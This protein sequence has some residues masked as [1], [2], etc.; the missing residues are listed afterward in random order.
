MK[1][2]TLLLLP[3]LFATLL[4]AEE[5]KNS[6]PIFIS[7]KFGTTVIRPK[8]TSA[9]TLKSRNVVKQQMDFSCGS[10]AVGTIFAFYLDDPIPEEMIIKGLFHFGNKENIVKNRGFSLLDIKKLAT[11]LGYK[12]AGYKTDI[13]GLLSLEQPAIVTITIGNYKHFVVFRG[14]EGNRVYLADPALGNMTVSRARFDEM[15]YKSIALVI[16]PKAKRAFD[17]KLAITEK[18]HVWVKDSQT[19]GALYTRMVPTL[20]GAG[21][22]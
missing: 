12:T 5:E 13:D 11:N 7:S 19:R 1:L 3:F 8:V 2:K 6:V 21:E 20:R 15:W 22:F 14:A 9:K 16:T 10:A 18:D 17:N 4:G